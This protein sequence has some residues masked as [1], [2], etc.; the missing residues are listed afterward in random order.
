MIQTQLLNIEY[1][2]FIEYIHSIYAK[3]SIG[4]KFKSMGEADSSRLFLL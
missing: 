2:I 1:S 4:N 3:Y